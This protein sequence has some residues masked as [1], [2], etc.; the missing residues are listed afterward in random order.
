MHIINIF[1]AI[2]LILFKITLSKPVIRCHTSSQ[3][4]HCSMKHQWKKCPDS[5][6]WVKRSWV[7]L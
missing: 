5:H 2:T 6:T 4:E 7:G 1:T 3:A